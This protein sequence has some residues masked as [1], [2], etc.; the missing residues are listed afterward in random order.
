MGKSRSISNRLQAEKIFLDEKCIYFL[1][2]MFC[3]WISEFQIKCTRIPLGDDDFL[4]G[5][6]IIFSMLVF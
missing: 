1:P 4:E 2:A 6:N 3:S 5:K